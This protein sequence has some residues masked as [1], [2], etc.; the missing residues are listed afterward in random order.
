MILN[1]F[2]VF[3]LDDFEDTELVR[4]TET[5]ALKDIGDV[6]VSILDGNLTSVVFDDVILSVNLNEKNPFVFEEHGV[7]LDENNDIWIGYAP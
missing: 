2:K 4:H 6:D 1:W 7:Y 5:F 3:N